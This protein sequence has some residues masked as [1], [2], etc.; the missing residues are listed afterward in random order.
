MATRSGLPGRDVLEQLVGR[1]AGTGASVSFHRLS[2]VALAPSSSRSQ[3]GNGRRARG[4]H[5]AQQVGVVPEP[6][7]D[8]VALEDRLD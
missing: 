3:G 1:S 8:R 7:L 5:L 2:I 6:A 4:G